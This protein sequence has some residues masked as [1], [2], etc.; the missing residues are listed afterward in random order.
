MADRSDETSRT[1]IGEFIASEAAGGI[2]LIAA[3]ALALIAANSPL[4]SAYFG[5]LHLQG[6]PLSVHHWV[7]DAMMAVFFLLVGLEI[8]RECIGGELARP[9]DRWLPA[10]AAAAGMAVPAIVYLAIVGRDPVL[11]RGWAIASATDIAFAMGVLAL[12]GRGVPP[13]LKLF[14]ATVAIVDD[15]GAVGIIA[16]AYTDAVELVPLAAA[17][18]ILAA[19]FAL[20][21][22]GVVRLSPYLAGALALWV[23]IYLSGIHAT[24]AGVL[25]ALAVPIR[26]DE[27]ASPL[28]RLEHAL[29]PWV[30]FLI[31]PL[32]GFA[33]AGVSFA[34]LTA[35]D[36][37]APLTLAIAGGLFLGKQ[38]GLT[39]ATWATVRL[40]LAA[41]PSGAG[42]PHVYGVGL[43]AG[44]GFTMSLFIGELAFSDP[45]QQAQMKIGVLAGSLLSALGGALILKVAGPTDA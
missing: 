29:A 8:K 42:W 35:A 41:R 32:F 11:A 15:M 4:S 13:A 12:L 22:A 7:N 27:A 24:I 40:G 25:A 45:M 30:G 33:N 37:L 34:G 1:P 16:L 10:I 6:G 19:M 43:I 21:R 39:L 38:V 44:I 5:L 23:A 31:V 2:V 36:L 9:A 18:A 14:L 28:H 3:A 17:A 26:R 20:N